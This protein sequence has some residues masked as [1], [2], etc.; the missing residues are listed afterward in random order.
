MTATI[1]TLSEF[2]LEKETISAYLE[3]ETIFYRQ[4]HRGRE[5]ITDSLN[6]YGKRNICTPS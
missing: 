2:I 4:W 3:C 1:G 6:R 5:T